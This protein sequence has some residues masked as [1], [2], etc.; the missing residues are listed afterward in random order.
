MNADIL[1]DL[2]LRT[3]YLDED[4]ATALLERNRLNLKLFRDGIKPCS[5]KGRTYKDKKWDHAVNRSTIRL[6]ETPWLP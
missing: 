1:D 3:G 6:K 4:R 5:V 2:M